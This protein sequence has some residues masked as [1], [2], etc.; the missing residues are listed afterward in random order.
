MAIANYLPLCEARTSPGNLGSVE[1]CVATKLEA[2]S[3]RTE[4]T[5]KVLRRLVPG[6]PCGPFVARTLSEQV[7]RTPMGRPAGELGKRAP[8]TSGVATSQSQT[9]TE[10]RELQQNNPLPEHGPHA[11]ATTDNESASRALAA[12]RYS[13]NRVRSQGALWSSPAGLAMPSSSMGLRRAAFVT[14]AQNALAD[15]S[16]AQRPKLNACAM[17][18][19]ISRGERQAPKG[20]SVQVEPVAMFSPGGICPTRSATPSAGELP[21]LADAMGIGGNGGTR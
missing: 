6:F 14:E 20:A 13:T 2:T 5:G 18:P 12:Q 17:E 19:N 21:L 9:A 16:S 7:C 10:Q 8:L 1:Q 3:N 15:R 4:C 11:P